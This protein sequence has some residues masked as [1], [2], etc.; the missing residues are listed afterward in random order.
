M[1]LTV[2]FLFFFCQMVV[3]AQIE[4]EVGPHGF[5]SLPYYVLRHRMINMV[6]GEKNKGPLNFFIKLEPSFRF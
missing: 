5:L 3:L 6:E 4:E 1:G 2:S